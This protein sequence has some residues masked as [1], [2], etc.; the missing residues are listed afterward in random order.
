MTESLFFVSACCFSI[1]CE[2][3]GV[4][5]YTGVTVAEALRDDI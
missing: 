5:Y 1:V 4:F 2:A 3:T